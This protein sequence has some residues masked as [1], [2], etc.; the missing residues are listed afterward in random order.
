MYESYEFHTWPKP[1]PADVS[2]FWKLRIAEVT[3]VQRSVT[4]C[5]GAGDHDREGPRA[6]LDKSEKNCGAAFLPMR[7]SNRETHQVGCVSPRGRANAQ[8]A[9]A[10][11]SK[12]PA[13]RELWDS[14]M[15]GGYN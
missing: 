7:A 2:S 5:P 13:A 3:H 12:N 10:Q 1:E 14:N 9:P 4:G 15:G 8:G 11:S 6:G